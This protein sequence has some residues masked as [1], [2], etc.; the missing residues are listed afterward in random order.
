MSTIDTSPLR[1]TTGAVIVDSAQRR[2]DQARR[3]YRRAYNRGYALSE[4]G[5]AERAQ[6]ILDQ[7]N[8][9]LRVAE[10]EYATARGR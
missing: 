9:V 7:A 4:Q 6:A 8:A 3:N 2:L 10:Q 5:D 1:T